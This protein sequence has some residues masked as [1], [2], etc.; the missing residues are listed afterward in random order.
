MST[1]S[2]EPLPRPRNFTRLDFD[3]MVD[4]GIVGED[5]R[6]E[7]VG[8][9]IV[10][11]SPEGP[12]HAGTIDLCAEALRRVFGVGFT[13][14]VQ[15]PLVIDPDGEPEP[16]LAVV[17]GEPRAHLDAHPRSAVLVVEVAESSLEFD[18]R[19][20]AVLYARAGIA[21]YWIVN[22]RDRIVEVRRGPTPVGYSSLVAMRPEDE[23]K[24]LSA[25][26][27]TVRVIDLLP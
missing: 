27:A 20:K 19:D 21:E 10:R 4:A 13:V 14:R 18:R 15:H 25:P 2:R 3:K 26:A 6:V 12:R 24:A 16:D 11:M 22:L 1:A 8:G 7:L 9:V 23:L 5:E 17:P